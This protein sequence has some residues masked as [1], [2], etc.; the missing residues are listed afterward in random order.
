MHQ[1]LVDRVTAA[2]V[3]WACQRLA[4]LSG[5]QWQAAFRAGG[6]APAAADRYIRKIKE[7]IAQ[8]LALKT[9]PTS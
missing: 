2:D 6:Y 5:E 3:V 8:G 1:G 9:P 7:K 4:Q